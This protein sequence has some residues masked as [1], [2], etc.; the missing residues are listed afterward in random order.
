MPVYTTP[1][2]RV[3][4]TATQP[5]SEQDIEALLG[6]GNVERG[7]KQALISH[8]AAS[9]AMD[10]YKA[11]AA[12]DSLAEQHKVRALDLARRAAIYAPDVQSVADIHG[13]GDAGAWAAGLA[14][15]LPVA[16]AP[17]VGAGLAGGLLGRRLGPLASSIGGTAGTVAGM[18]LPETDAAALQQLQAEQGGAPVLDPRTALDSFR[19]E[20]WTKGAIYGGVGP[21]GGAVRST[22]GQ[23]ARV[24]ARDALP[25]FGTR[26]LH[27]ATTGA[28]TMAGAEM[29]GQ[30][31]ETERDP[32]R[33]TSHDT[34]RLVDAAAAGGALAVPFVGVGHAADVLHSTVAGG[35]DLA[36]R[37]VRAGVGTGAD[38]AADAAPKIGAALGQAWDAR[39]KSLD[40]A[41]LAMGKG[42]AEMHNRG[43]D[44]LDAAL[45]PNH[46]IDYLVKPQTKGVDLLADDA[47][48]NEKATSLS[49]RILQDDK[50]PADLKTAAQNFMAGSK[51]RD[52]WKVVAQAVDSVKYGE[53]LGENLTKLKIALGQG[54]DKADKFKEDMG[55][56]YNANLKKNAQLVDM[57]NTILAKHLFDTKDY[58]YADH[59]GQ[60]YGIASTLRDW[61]QGG[62][63][64]GKPPSVLARIFKEPA[65]A[66]ESTYRLMKQQGLVT[67][68]K[69]GKNLTT[70]LDL[71]LKAQ[72]SSNADAELVKSS[73]TPVARAKYAGHEAKLAELVK[74]HLDQLDDAKLDELFGPQKDAVLEQLKREPADLVTGEER[75]GPRLSDESRDDLEK[76]GGGYEELAGMTDAHNPS[77][78][79]SRVQHHFFNPV[80]EAPYSKSNGAHDLH[81]QQKAK[82]LEGNKSRV[83][84]Q[85]FLDALRE[86][87]RDD[88]AA[89]AAALESAKEKGYTNEGHYV[90]REEHPSDKR[91]MVDIPGAEFS[92]LTPGAKGNRWAETTGIK[93]AGGTPEH[94]KIFFERVGPDGTTTQFATSTS[95]IIKRMRESM[96][97]DQPGLAG[98]HDMLMAGI[99][100]LLNSKH[101]DGRL[102]LSGRIGFLHEGEVQWLDAHDRLPDNLRMHAKGSSLGEARAMKADQHVNRLKN[103]LREFLSKDGADKALRD[104]AIAALRTGKVKDLQDAMSRVEAKTEQAAKMAVASKSVDSEKVL[105]GEVGRDKPKK[106]AGDVGFL[107]TVRDENGK[108]LG[109][110]RTEHHGIGESEEMAAAA[111]KKAQS[112]VRGEDPGNEL[113]NRGV[114]KTHTPDVSKGAVERVLEALRKGL[115]AFGEALKGA[116]PDSRLAIKKVL[117]RM[118][119]ASSDDPVWNKNPPKDMESFG[120]R[121]RR[122]LLQ[123]DP[124]WKQRELD[125]G[126]EKLAPGSSNIAPGTKVEVTKPEKANP[127]RDPDLEA[128]AR[129]ERATTQPEDSQL[130]REWLVK[131]E[132]AKPATTMPMKFAD[133][134]VYNGIT[135]TMRPEFKGKS[136]LDLIQSGDRTATTRMGK[137]DAKPGDIIKMD[138]GRG[139]TDDVRVTRDPYQLK[140]FGDQRDAVNAE[141][142]SKLEGWAPSVYEA[143]AKK[144]AWQM[145]YERVGAKKNVQQPLNIWHGSGQN[146]HL[147]N[148]AERKF[149]YEGRNYRSVEHAYQSNKSGKFDDAAYR[150]G[151]HAP[152]VVGGMGTKIAENWNI[153]LMKN[154]MLESFKQNPSAA[155]RLLE[156]GDA[157]FTHV[158]DRGVWRETFPRLLH[159]VRN[160]LAG[161][162]ENAQQERVALP[163]TSPYTA[164]DQAKS[165]KANKFIGRGSPASSTTAY[166]KAWGARSNSG[167][168]TAADRVFLS[169]EGARGGRKALDTTELQKALDAGATIITDNSAN[170]SR[171]YNIGEREAEA[172][173]KSHG[174]T[175][176]E[177]GVWTQ[178]EKKNAQSNLQRPT[179]NTE[180]RATP[181]EIKAANDYIDK[182]LGP[183]MKRAFLDDLGGHS[184][185][186]TPDAQGNAI[187]V[188]T[189]AVGGV[190]TNAVHE[191]MHEFFSRLVNGKQDA[192]RDLLTRVTSNQIVTRSLERILADHPEALAAMKADPEERLAYAYQFWE[193]GHPLMK[194]GPQAT[195][196]FERVAK[197][198]RSVTGLLRDDEK[199]EA[200]FRQFNEGKLQ[201]PSV[202]GK[203]IADLNNSEKRVAAVANTVEPFRKVAM[204]WVG[205]AEDNLLKSTNPILQKIGNSFADHTDGYIQGHDRAEKQWM[206]KLKQALHPFEKDDIA[207]ALEGLQTGNLSSDKTIRA[208]QDN[209]RSLLD[210]MHPYLEKAGVSVM[211]EQTGQWKPIGKRDNYFP[212]S[213]SMDELYKRGPEFVERLM[214][215]HASELESIATKANYEVTQGIL[216]GKGTASQTMLGKSP[217]D[218]TTIT[219]QD[220]ADAIYARLMGTNGQHDLANSMYSLGFSPMMKAVNRRTLDWIDMSKFHDFQNKDI[221]NIMSSYV[222]QATKRAEYTRRF[223]PD[224]SKLSA[225]MDNARFHEIDKLVKAEYDIDGA[226]KKA[227]GAMRAIKAVN[228]P[229]T[230]FEEQLAKIINFHGKNASLS[231][232]DA[233]GIVDLGM[234]QLIPA[235]RAVLAME[236]TLGHDI[237]PTLRKA[238]GWVLAYQNWRMLPLALFSNLIDPLGILVR[239]GTMDDTFKAYKSAL[240]DVVNSWRGKDRDD[241]L[242]QMHELI[243]TLDAHGYLSSMGS[244]MNSMYMGGGAK[245]MNDML[246]K[247]NGMEALNRSMRSSATQAAIG[248]IKRHAETPNEHSERLL[249]EMKL[250]AAYVKSKIGKG[251]TEAMGLDVTDPRIQN[252]VSQWVNEAILRPTSAQRPSR[253]SDPHWALFSHFKGFMYSMHKQILTRAAREARYGNYTAASTLALGYIP[254][255]FA[256]DMAKLITQNALAG[257]AKLPAWWESMDAKDHFLY[258]GERAGLLGPAQMARDAVEYGP[259]AIGGPTTEQVTGLFTDPLGKSAMSALPWNQ[260]FASAQRAVND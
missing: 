11:R 149:T 72:K 95:K 130:P 154:L 158:Q 143:Y 102:A 240:S 98:Q 168:Y 94:G 203:I 132:A 239:G 34:M 71:A 135:H 241:N 9:A 81:M 57:F 190:H 259:S 123:I 256:S 3:Y 47:V 136:T 150:G 141:K 133:G 170:R 109:E 87:Y 84:V 175:E 104:Q 28:G 247:V 214:A 70:V 210:E 213:W 8:D 238:Q 187:R 39:P 114:P 24:T 45:N 232:K 116:K 100:S 244:M 14:G 53:Q 27:D 89:H 30:H 62:F 118:L 43:S 178:V 183:Q 6:S 51:E 86:K 112:K 96:S 121:A 258:A 255:M 46:E 16:M 138:N 257:N 85:G 153:G 191:S 131:I 75:A 185:D 77:T 145:Q 173:L 88:P 67:D 193:A 189:N 253:M 248:F 129:A 159:E 155:K 157:K 134:T 201:D 223:G 125:L 61:V 152:M 192:V 127:L 224:G 194:L 220:V 33:D 140:W 1:G 111:E 208:V 36:A 58:R 63:K 228:G 181:E 113:A 147:S 59:P 103:D 235:Q 254:V 139:G 54:I 38:F 12:G 29:A 234:Q 21:V 167:V 227:A 251:P 91:D 15:G 124:Q 230:T 198:F 171:S 5:A 233:R 161:T 126:D 169:V 19:K 40:E 200:I 186:W 209:V 172:Y 120:K 246:F 260:F 250:D 97:T 179:L 18:A 218:R 68:E 219:A 13:L 165:D 4:N 93:H 55:L 160:E 42:A 245:R 202:A 137:P 196:F 20:G 182:T 204:D 215:E 92:A 151:F 231:E 99:S 83:S 206:G 195:S 26:L 166:A 23:G 115:P 41:A 242:T 108:A 156:T 10:A 236:G 221:V 128:A 237:N 119:R 78:V 184:A 122:A 217:K 80:A 22:L 177:P 25:G 249:G 199:V 164:K 106:T 243:G 44:V 7:L 225:E 252:A 37:G 188:A 52:A 82:S 107:S 105:Y 174:Y 148:L 229:E 2:A 222:M 162:K 74:D 35:T 66:I 205:S 48:R 60:F 211:D 64:G 49:E 50:A 216:A 73:L 197:F 17:A 117:E 180:K 69:Q 207:A 163:K 101:E 176:S 144:G 142:W 146:A 90:L 212:R 56:A 32:N 226:S 79:E 31:F 65:A 110:S 76:N